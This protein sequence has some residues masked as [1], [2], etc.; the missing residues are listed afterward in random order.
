MRKEQ[1]ADILL[2]AARLWQNGSSAASELLTEDGFPLCIEQIVD[3]DA[4]KCWESAA[5]SE[6]SALGFDIE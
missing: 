6:V 5:L 2:C 1:K 3:I 4:M